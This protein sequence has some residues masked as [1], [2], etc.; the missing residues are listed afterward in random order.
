MVAIPLDHR[1]LRL[2][3]PGGTTGSHEARLRSPAGRLELH[4]PRCP[5]PEQVHSSARES[6]GRCCFPKRPA[7]AGGPI[8]TFEEETR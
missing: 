4:P 3:F 6:R 5:F 7:V 8:A 2:T 1:V